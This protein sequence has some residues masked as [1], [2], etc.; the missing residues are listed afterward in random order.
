MTFCCN[1]TAPVDKLQ[2][3]HGADLVLLFHA[4]LAEVLRVAY[5]PNRAVGVSEEGADGVGVG[6]PILIQGPCAVGGKCKAVTVAFGL[7]RQPQAVF[8]VGPIAGE[9]IAGCLLYTSDA[10]DE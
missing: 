5:I 10:A 1:F 7:C 4:R 6:L 8:A 2:L 3:L 9:G